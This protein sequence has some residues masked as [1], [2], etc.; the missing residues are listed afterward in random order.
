MAVG[1]RA[2][3][4]ANDAPQ[5]ATIYGGMS[6][7]YAAGDS[8][9]YGTATE[10]AIHNF[11]NVGDATGLATADNVFSFTG[12]SATQFC[13]ATNAVIDHALQCQVNGVTYWI[14]LYDATA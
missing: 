3:Y 12:L 7:L 4:F 8:T 5:A 9:D 6:E 2:T 13:A 10:H 1:V 11:N 14:G